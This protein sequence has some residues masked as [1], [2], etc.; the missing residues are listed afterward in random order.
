MQLGVLLGLSALLGAIAIFLTYFIGTV[1]D[2]SESNTIDE[3]PPSDQ[4]N[5]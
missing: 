5:Q 4:L 2:S 1:L 3:L